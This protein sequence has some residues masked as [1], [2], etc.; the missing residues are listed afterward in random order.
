[1]GFHNAV[2]SRL[3]KIRGASANEI[4][5]IMEAVKSTVE[6]LN[7]TGP[8]GKS[9]RLLWKMF[10][11]E[12]HNEKEAFQIYS[13]IFESLRLLIRNALFTLKTMLKD[14]LVV[15]AAEGGPRHVIEVLNDT[16][17]RL[18]ADAKVFF[19][20]DLL[21]ILQNM[22]ETNVQEMVL[23]PCA[24]VVVRM[25]EM[26]PEELKPSL[27]TTFVC[28]RLV[29]EL[30]DAFLSVLIENTFVDAS[31]RFNMVALQ[32]MDVVPNSH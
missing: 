28:E 4:D 13:K 23:V 11:E 16:V 22:I 1:M 18:N 10:T 17:S 14:E 15:S 27:T 9:Q 25:K 31:S 20:D 5:R 32:L 3:D 12:M 26:V 8:M 19:R 2:R 21:S 7:A 24:D 6:L 29:R 30:V